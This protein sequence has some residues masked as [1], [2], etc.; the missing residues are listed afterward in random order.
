M[1]LTIPTFAAELGLL[2]EILITLAAWFAASQLCRSI[3]PARRAL[4]TIAANQQYAAAAYI[5]LWDRWSD[6]NPTVS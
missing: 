5:D 6:G 1:T 4:R 3:S 2:L